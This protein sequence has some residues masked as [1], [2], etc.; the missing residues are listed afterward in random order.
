M[1]ILRNRKYRL[2]PAEEGLYRLIA[3]RDFKTSRGAGIAIK[4]GDLGGRVA[5]PHNL[6]HKGNCWVEQGARVLDKARVRK[7]ALVLDSA[8]VSG[9]ALVTDH[10]WVGGRAHVSGDAQIME[11][12]AVLDNATVR[13]GATVR[14][15]GMVGGRAVVEHRAKVEDG[16]TVGDRTRVGG[17]AVIRGPETILSGDPYIVMG[18]H[19][20]GNQG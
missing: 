7:D 15:A 1:N 11:G 18:V 9:R 4:K 14:T 6:S 2:E 8:T 13:D 19:E 12:G 5:G 16:A 20:D 17:L 3:V 10:S